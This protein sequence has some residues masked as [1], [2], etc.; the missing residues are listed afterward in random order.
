M[1]RIAVALALALLAAWSLSVVQAATYDFEPTEFHVKL[2]AAAAPAL[3][4]EPGDTVRTTTID[5][6]GID[7]AGQRRS[8]PPNPLTGP[9]FVKGAAPGD[10]LVVHIKRLRLNRDTA[11][12]KNQLEEHTLDPAYVETRPTYRRKAEKFEDVYETWLLDRKNMIARLEKPSERLRAFTVKLEPMLGSIG[13]APPNDEAAW[14]YDVGDFGGN[15]DYNRIKEGAV[16][17]LPVFNAGALLFL[18]D[19]H[20]LQANGEIP[21]TGLETSVDVEFEVGLLKGRSLGQPYAEDS[22]TMMMSGIRKSFAEAFQAATTGMARWLTETYGLDDA[23]LAFV[24]GTSIDYDIAEVVS[25]HIHIVAKI[26]KEILKQLP[27]R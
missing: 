6:G 24:M 16:L 14:A 26:P 25:P 17:Y 18:G 27:V 9:F 13:V 11:I 4:I 22:A 19:A 23:E 21:G 2:S 20:A 1:N 8:A 5:A 3:H 15:L 7:R 12:S 10:T